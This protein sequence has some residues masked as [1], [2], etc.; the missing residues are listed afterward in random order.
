MNNLNFEQLDQYMLSCNSKII[1]QIW[2]FNGILPRR[3][4]KKVFNSLNKYRD[5]W[6][7]KNPDW[8][9]KCWDS[10]E[11]LNIVKKFYPE[12]LNMYKNYNY[13][14]QRCD[15]I[16]YFI[17]HRYGGLYADM[18][19]CCVKPW[20]EVL[21]LYKSDIYFV[22]TPNK[23]TQGVHVSNSLM[24]SRKNNSFWRALFIEL[25]QNKNLPIYYG[26]HLTIMYS[27]GPCIINRVF[28]RYKSKYKLKSYPFELFHPYGIN[29]D[30]D[31]NKSLT[32]K[33]YAYHLGKGSW[34]N[35]DTKILIF[36]YVEYK[37]LLVLILVLLFPLFIRLIR[38]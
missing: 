7:M 19:Y 25:E 12:H 38:I 10:D 21:R 9:Y 4:S 36:L 18:D 32:N 16:R 37:I 29:V 14:I 27:T 2:F 13:E 11:A 31:T 15:L 17:L 24:Y 1:H 22:E 5:T 23:M 34:E 26:R 35:Q 33:I 28:Q 6:I 30:L 3:Q 8:V 20:N